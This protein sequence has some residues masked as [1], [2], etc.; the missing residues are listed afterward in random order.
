MSDMPD[1]SAFIPSRSLKLSSRPSERERL[2][3]YVDE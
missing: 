1:A 3:A 2:R